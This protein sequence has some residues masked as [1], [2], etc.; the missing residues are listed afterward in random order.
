[1]GGYKMRKLIVTLGAPGSGKSYWIK[2]N[3]LGPY[4]IEVDNIRM[5]Y[6]SPETIA[7]NGQ[8][9]LDQSISQSYN[10]EVFNTAYEMLENRMKHGMT[11]VF[12]SIILYK[13]AWSPINKLVKKYHYKVSYSN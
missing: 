6:A 11:T 5:L 12:D 13:K 4:T 1:M 7:I 3:D 10:K 8:D 9:G 2:Q